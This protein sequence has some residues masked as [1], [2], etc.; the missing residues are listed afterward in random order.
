MIHPKLPKIPMPCFK[1]TNTQSSLSRRIDIHRL[2]VLRLQ[3]FT[4]E[5]VDQPI[6]ELCILSA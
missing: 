4:V 3:P 2:R 5:G 6:T 1:N